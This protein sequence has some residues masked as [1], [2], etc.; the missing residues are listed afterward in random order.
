MKL[1]GSVTRVQSL[2]NATIT[3]FTAPEDGWYVVRAINNTTTS[4]TVEALVW[5]AGSGHSSADYLAGVR[6]DGTYNRAVTPPLYLKEGAKVDVRS[7]YGD[8]GDVCKLT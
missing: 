8:L 2:T 7:T 5:V 3:E 1:T 4:K 6:I